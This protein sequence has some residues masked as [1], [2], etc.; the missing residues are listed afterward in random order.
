MLVIANGLKKFKLVFNQQLRKKK[1]KH[2]LWLQFDLFASSSMCLLH[3]DW[4]I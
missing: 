4:G 3:K 1:D 2:K